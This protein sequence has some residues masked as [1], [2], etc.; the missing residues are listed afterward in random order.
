MTRGKEIQLAKAPYNWLKASPLL[1]IPT[2]L[3]ITSIVSSSDIFYFLCVGDFDCGSNGKQSMEF[4]VGVLGSALWH[5]L[6]L[7]YVNNKE[8]ELVRE[9]GRKALIQAGIRTGVAFFGVL[10]DWLLNAEGAIACVIIIALL[11]IWAINTTQSKNWVEGNQPPAPDMPEAAPIPEIKPFVQPTQEMLEQTLADLDSEDDVT[12]LATIDKLGGFEKVNEAILKRLEDLAD[13]DDNKDVRMD[14]RVVFNRLRSAE[15]PIR[16]VTT[17]EGMEQSNPGKPDVVLDKLYK[18][19]QSEDDIVILQAIAELANLNYSSVAIRRRLEKLAVSSD[20]PPVRSDALNALNSSANRAVQRQMTAGKLERSIRL[21]VL[22]EIADWET[23]ELLNKQTADALRR[24]YDFDVEPQAAPKIVSPQA[25]IPMPQANSA[26][27]TPAEAP[28]QVAA[29]KPQVPAEPRPSL[30]QTL[31]SESAIRIYLYLGAFFV[32]AAAA[33]L[34]AVVESLRLPILMIGTL[35]FGG[36]AVLIKKRLPQPSFALF[37][38]FS[39]LLPITGISL[40]EFLRQ[41]LGLS[42]KFSDWYWVVLFFIMALIWAGSTRL[43]ESRFFAVAAYL[44]LILSFFTTGIALEAEFPVHTFLMGLAALIGLAWTQTIKRWKDSKFAFPI[45]IIAQIVEAAVLAFSIGSFGVNLLDASFEPLFFLFSFATWILGAVFYIASDFVLPFFAFSWLASAAFIPMP[46][47]IAAAFQLE[48]LGGAILMPAWGGVLAVV[49]EALHRIE[50]GRKFNIPLLLASLPSLALGIF[51]GFIEATWLGLAAALGVGL[52][53]TI[54]NILRNRS[55]LWSLALFNFIV[56]YFAFFQLDPISKLEIAFGY[57]LVGI[58]LLFLLPDLFMKKDW[59]DRLEWRLP[60]RIFGALF[61]IAASILLFF[62][63]EP[64]QTAVGFGIFALFCTAYAFLYRKPLLGYISAAYLPLAVI[65][66]LDSLNSDAWLPALTG[67]AV[68]YYLASIALRSRAGWGEMLRNSGLAIGTITSFTALILSKEN[69]GLYALVIGLLFIAETYLS[70]KGIFEI[71]APILFTLGAFLVLSDFKVFEISKHL[72]TYSLIWVV[73]DAIFHL[74]FHHPRPWRSTIRISGA[75]LTLFTSIFVITEGSNSLAAFCFGTYTLLFLAL[76]LIHKT[77]IFGYVPAVYL[78]L[79]AVFTLEH[80]NIDAWL[81]ALTGISI[82]YFASGLTV[83]A[84]EDWSLM[85]RNSALA[86][87]VLLSIAAL[88]LLKETGGW[89]TLPIGMLFIAEM[90]LLKN[91]WFEVGAPAL[92]TLGAFLILRDFDVERIEYHLLAYSTIWILE[93]LAAHRAFPIPRPLALLIRLAG[94]LTALVNYGFLI[95][96]ADSSTAAFG[97]ALYALLF[98]TVSLVYRQPALLYT[99][100]LTLPLFA[101]FLFRSFGLTQW[102]HPVIVVAAFYY[103]AGFFLRKSQNAKGWESPLLNSGLGLG[104]IVSVGAVILGGLDASIP[105][106]VAATLWAVEAFAKRNAWLAFPANALYLTAYLVILFDLNVNEPQFFSV[107][108][109]LFGLIQHY[110]LTR[111]ENK[112]GTFVMG[113]VSQLTLLGTTYIEMINRNDLN[114]FF[115]LF[116]QSLV[117]LVY[118]IVIRSRSLTFFPIG[119]VALGVVTV[120]YSALKDRAAIFVIGCTGI[121]LLMLGVGAV[122][123]RER[124]AKLGEKLSDWK[125]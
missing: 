113:M 60:L 97:F 43:Y 119:F 3:F 99:F 33:I 1:T 104:V 122:L 52:L 107:G 66:G 28:A 118:G 29:P 36:I 20:S 13:E 53:F 78:P 120:T 86:L 39:F 7:Q 25:A 102:I 9:H 112:T 92:F 74:T 101:T 124:I 82:L 26:K 80:F 125:A 22:H 63:E 88:S 85:L 93:D 58:T 76:S 117:I 114:Y 8:S 10:L 69:G 50:R 106:A 83:R 30:L 87:G 5:L 73:L 42:N 32:I 40:E 123:L 96:N 38:V 81:P 18:L 108:V 47:F 16:T 6:L 111:A 62:A 91:G 103:G 46:W 67:L 55:W 71:G 121:L 116:I 14:A 72:F 11:L 89:Y 95:F 19:L 34:G 79:T 109:A 84:K 41:S 21:A 2:L 45:L 115:L 35:V 48:S 27:P 110:L 54:L 105:V 94:G 64:V 65:Y 56:A 77:P 68:I 37:I 4:A 17:G 51:S 44:S 23:S 98:L 31:T 59:Q 75:A 15:Q 70:R 57:Q 24:R 12:V 100:T 90:Y 61:L 49:S